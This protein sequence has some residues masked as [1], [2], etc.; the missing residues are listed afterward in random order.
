MFVL[1]FIF[2]FIGVKYLPLVITYVSI[3][4]IC[5][6]YYLLYD[7]ISWS[8]GLLLVLFV[9]LRQYLSDVV[10]TSCISLI[11]NRKLYMI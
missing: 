3:T 6:V 5:L 8:T 11:L 1:C 7:T 4:N 10:M 2:I 9:K